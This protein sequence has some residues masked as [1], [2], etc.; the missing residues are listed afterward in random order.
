MML[1]IGG[2]GAGIVFIAAA[3]LCF[4]VAL[5]FDPRRDLNILIFLL[6]GALL[7]ASG[8]SLIAGAAFD[9]RIR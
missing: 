6:C 2:V 9:G 5:R 8:L 4:R 1:N 3:A 7:V